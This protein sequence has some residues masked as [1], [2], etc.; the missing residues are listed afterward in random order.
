MPGVRSD[1]AISRSYTWPS[2]WRETS[3][4]SDTWSGATICCA[5]KA[6]AASPNQAT[7]SF[8]AGDPTPPVTAAGTR[9][10]ITLVATTKI[11]GMAPRTRFTASSDRSSR[12]PAD[13]SNATIRR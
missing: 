13:G 8:H 11:T 12:R 7:S 3:S 2:T 4:P 5:T 10:I 9:P 1:A 6:A